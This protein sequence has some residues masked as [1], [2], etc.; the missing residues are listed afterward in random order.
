MDRKI[1]LGV[2][3]GSRGRWIGNLRRVRSD[4]W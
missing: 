3:G 1:E 4:F 2:E